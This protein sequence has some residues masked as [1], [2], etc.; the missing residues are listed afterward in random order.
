MIQS[1]NDHPT[2]LACK[3]CAAR[4]RICGLVDFS[5]CGADFIAGKTSSVPNFQFV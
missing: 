5:R 4:A 1:L 2:A 3:V